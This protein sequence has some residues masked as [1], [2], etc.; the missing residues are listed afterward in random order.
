MLNK[1]GRKKEDDTQQGGNACL[2]VTVP[3]EPQCKSSLGIVALIL[4]IL[5][6]TGL[7]LLF[8]IYIY[9][10]I[11]ISIIACGFGIAAIATGIMGQMNPGANKGLALAGIII[12]S[13]WMAIFIAIH[14]LDALF[15][16]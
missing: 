8:T 3:T 9:Y 1:I 5:S 7:L 6:Y 11:Y 12:G 14:L 10:V 16:W 2:E 15:F 4:G 13:S